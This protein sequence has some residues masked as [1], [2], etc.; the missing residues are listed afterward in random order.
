MLLG[1]GDVGALLAP[2][3]G[4]ELRFGAQVVYA[5]FDEAGTTMRDPTGLELQIL[6]TTARIVTGSL[7]GLKEESV[8][9][10]PATRVQYRV[11][12]I[13]PEGDGALSVLTL[14]QA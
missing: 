5:V 4:E 9:T 1:A 2:P 14:A 10:R 12:Q 13:L 3:V 7:Q 8:V 11:R 6:G